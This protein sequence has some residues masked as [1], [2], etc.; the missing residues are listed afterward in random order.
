VI[1]LSLL[2]PTEDKV[3]QTWRFEN[4]SLIRIGRAATN[5]VVLYS[6]VVSRHHLELQRKPMFW[7]AVNLS[8]NGS[9]SDNKAIEILKIYNGMVIRLASTGPR[10]QISLDD[11]EFQARIPEIS[12]PKIPE[13]HPSKLPERPTFMPIKD[14]DRDPS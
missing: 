13:Y 12:Q 5:Q 4:E 9:F 6:S 3:A 14:A 11:F 8:A 10:L 1:T 2:H 7:Q